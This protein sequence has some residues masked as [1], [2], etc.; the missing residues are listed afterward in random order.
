[1]PNRILRE[2]ILS[3]S[4]VDRLSDG[5]EIF[6]RRLHSVVDDYGRHECHP[7]LLRTKCYPLRVDRV[8][9]KNIISWLEE[10]EKA[11]LLVVYRFG[12]K[13]Y[14]QLLDWRQQVRSESKC[15]A[16]DEQLIR[17]CLANA[18]VSC[19]ADDA[20]MISLGGGVVVVGGVSEGGGVSSA[21]ATHP[22]PKNGHKVEFDF[23]K[24]EFVGITERDE[25]R[26]QEAYPAVPIPPAIAQAAAWLK[27]NPANKKSNYERFLVGWFKRD[28][29]KAARVK[30]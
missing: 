16:P 24:G 13:T 26:W 17:K 30:R 28:Q 25:L 2:G 11:A 7:E 3:S 29:D 4:R 12:S 19:D 5:G 18:H 8:R 15:P 10:C 14:L 6:Y 20:Q 22:P 1:M 21:A 9:A 27:A 23:L